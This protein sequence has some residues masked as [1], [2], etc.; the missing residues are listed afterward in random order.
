MDSKTTERPSVSIIGAGLIGLV[1]GRTLAK[2]GFRV[3]IFEQ[4]S[5]IGG[6]LAPVRV[7]NESLELIPHHLRKQDKHIL[8][9]YTEL[10]LNDRLEWFDA[11]W[12]G[13]ARTRKLGY[14]Q[15]GFRS[16]LTAMNQDITDRNGII[17]YGHTVID[18][19]RNGENTDIP[20]PTQTAPFPR[21][22]TT[23]AQSAQAYSL[24]CVLEN[25]STVVF[26]TDIVLYTASCRNFANITNHLGLPTDY[27]DPLMDVT[28]M[29]NLCL[30]LLSKKHCTDCYSKP[31]PTTAPF[32]KVIE[33]TNLVGLRNYGGHILYLTGAMQPTDPLWTQSDADVYNVC[34]NHLRKLTP[35][36]SK[37]DILSWRLTRTRYALPTAQAST[38]LRIADTGIYLCSMSMSTVDNNEFRMDSC[39]EIA[40]ESCKIIEKRHTLSTTRRNT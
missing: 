17:Y 34:I 4:H 23:A 9:L 27:T 20:P 29:G 8:E 18:I 22:Q 36:L 7:G 38:G 10:G 11:C 2:M 40:L 12:Y 30:L 21:P 39:V 35:G 5:M 6:M 24:S 33:H 32:Q 16:L 31:F 25:G 3:Q 28:Y 26:G 14:P 19:R 1:C 13:K 15:D 37:K